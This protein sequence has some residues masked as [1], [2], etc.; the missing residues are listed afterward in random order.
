M[1]KIITLITLI[2]FGG[3]LTMENK[4]LEKYEIAT[5]SGGCFWCSEAAFQEESGVIEVISGYVGGT[6]EN[7]T[8][9]QVSSGNTD[10]REGVQVYYNPKEISYNKLLEIFWKHIDPTQEDGQFNDRGNHYTTAI[11]YNNEIEKNLAI[12]SRNDL[13][14]SNKFNK[15]ITTKI[16]PYSTFVKAEEYHQ[17]YYIKQSNNYEK[18]AI[19]SGRKDYIKKTWEKEEY[20]KPNENELKK[21]LTDYQYYI[22]QHEGTEKAFENEY[23]D[24]KEE[25]IYVDVVT[26]EPLFSSNDKYDSKTGW[27]SFTKPINENNIIEESDYKIG[28]ERTE[29]RSKSGDTHLGHVFN[30]GPID[31]GGQ[32]YCINSASLR[33]IPKKDLEKEGYGKYLSLF[34]S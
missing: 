11:Y 9:E 8:Y 10:Y 32:R 27:P 5:F 2:L 29:V 21:K 34:N 24:N 18:Y 17:D 19:G 30:D 33:F 25:G 20:F 13:N 12:K 15:P 3:N 22:T 26:G 4:N 28:I 7:P 23:W 16:L 1:F 14:K 31:K 6:S